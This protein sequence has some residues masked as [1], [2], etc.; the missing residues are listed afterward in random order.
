MTTVSTD[1]LADAIGELKQAAQE[2][3]EAQTVEDFE[4]IERKLS[5]TD[6]LF[7]EAQ[8]AMW[9]KE[10]QATLKR[11]ERNEPLGESDQTVLRA[12][13]ISDAAS[14]LALENDYNDWLNEFER[15][16]GDLEKRVRTMTRE[17]I[18]DARGVLKD[19]IRLTPDIRNY[20]DERTRV[21][22]CEAA[23][24]NLDRPSRETL[25]KLLAEQLRN[26]KR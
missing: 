14:Y 10:A 3:L 11:L 9:V 22:R 8:Q 19:A 5:E 24:K 26:S 21:A 23:L 13:L 7:R 20:L 18:A 16:I 4:A 1:Y 12:F 17:T 15:L 25:A 6:T 2:A